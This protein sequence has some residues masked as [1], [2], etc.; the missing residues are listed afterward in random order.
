MEGMERRGVLVC[1]T[2]S[3]GLQGKGALL[4]QKNSEDPPS[5]LWH[6]AQVLSHTHTMLKPAEY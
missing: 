1:P 6:M 4:W 2:D 3:C 5:P